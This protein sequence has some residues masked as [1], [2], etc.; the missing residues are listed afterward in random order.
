[1]K[2]SDRNLHEPVQEV[3]NGVQGK[4]LGNV[5]KN[6]PRSDKLLEYPEEAPQ[7]GGNCE[8]IQWMEST[9]IQHLVQNDNGLAQQKEGGKQGISPSTFYQK[10]TSQQTTQRREEEQE[11]ELEETILPKLH[12]SRN[13]KR[14]H[15]QCLQHGQNLD[16]I[17]R[18]RGTKN[19]TNSSPKEITLSLDV[20]N[21]LTEIKNSILPLKEIKKQLIIFTRKK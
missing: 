6:S 16:G 20:V 14:C 8:I 19:A 2:G 21:T 11:K 13:Q 10:S 17:Q 1:L 15:G 5:S 3:L 18:Q 12:D 4:R 7:R 9:I